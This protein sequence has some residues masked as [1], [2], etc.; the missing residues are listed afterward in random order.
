MGNYFLSGIHGRYIVKKRRREG[1]N[2]KNT[3]TRQ[4]NLNIPVTCRQLTPGMNIEFSVD[5]LYM[6]IQGFG[7]NENRSCN[8]LVTEPLD[9]QLQDALFPV[10]KIVIQ[11]G[12]SG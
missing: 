5:I 12:F 8:F 4:R 3:G 2:A 7:G 9:Q 10:G 11:Q 1:R 6:G